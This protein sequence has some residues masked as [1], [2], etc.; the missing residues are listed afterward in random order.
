[1][2]EG[3]AAVPELRER[4]AKEEAAEPGCLYARLESIDPEAS[5]RIHRNDLKRQIRALEFYEVTGQPIS[6]A[7]K[8]F[9][10]AGWRV[11]CRIA[12]VSRDRDAL[13]ARVKAR[14]VAM[15]KDGLLEETAAINS[16][17]GFSNTAGGAIGYAECLH[18]LRV[19]YKDQ[20][21]LRNRIRRSTHRLIRRQLAWLRRVP[22]VQWFN[23]ESSVQELRARFLEAAGW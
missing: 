7:R 9:D 16:D 2:M 3:P 17:C 18:H 11:P 12:A 8:Q 19:G 6:R 13:R 20:E 14:T 23:P 22:E 4:L 10:S 15:L 1:M 5:E 21:E